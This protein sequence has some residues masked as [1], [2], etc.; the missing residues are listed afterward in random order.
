MH[1]RKRIFRNL[2]ER[3][4]DVICLQET[5]VT[6]E[7]VEQWRKEWGGELTFFEGTKHGKGQMILVK[8]TFRLNGQ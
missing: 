6:E 3:K 4:L 2:K 1:K 8:K 7:V 5:Y